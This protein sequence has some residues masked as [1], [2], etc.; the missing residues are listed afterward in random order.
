V[1]IQR[2]LARRVDASLHEQPD[3]SCLPHT[4]ALL[5]WC[6]AQQR[7]AQEAKLLK[8]AG[9]TGGADNG[10]EENKRTSYK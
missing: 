3:P 10:D 2:R 4:L 6:R 8:R 9:V 1:Q 5:H 7:A